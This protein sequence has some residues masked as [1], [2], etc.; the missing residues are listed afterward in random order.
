MSASG[1]VQSGGSHSGK[2]SGVSPKD[3]WWVSW[4]LLKE[5]NILSLNVHCSVWSKENPMTAMARTQ[6]K[7]SSAWLVPR[8]VL[9]EEHPQ[10][11]RHALS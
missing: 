9:S 1:S 10:G 8:A 5:R 4:D 7:V 2:M 3:N 11:K 6:F